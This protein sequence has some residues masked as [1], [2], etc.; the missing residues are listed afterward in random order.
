MIGHHHAK[1]TVTF[2][3]IRRWLCLCK[4]R[5]HAPA[6][7]TPN[8]TLTSR[9]RLALCALCAFFLLP[10]ATALAAPPDLSLYTGFAYGTQATQSAAVLSGML[11]YRLMAIA[12]QQ[13]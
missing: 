13:G 4:D 3:E 12:R 9:L 6:Y 8:M 10:I 2:R 7:T 1:S 11:V 5:L